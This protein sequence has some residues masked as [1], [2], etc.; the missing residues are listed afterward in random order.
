MAMQSLYEVL[1][2]KEVQLQELQRLLNEA[3]IVLN[4]VLELNAAV[5]GSARAA[6]TNAR[7]AVQTPAFRPD[8]GRAEDAAA[9]R[10]R[11]LKGMPSSGWGA[12][13]ST[14]FP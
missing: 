9:V 8:A 1:R 14:E 3:Q 13:V 5:N 10:E 6:Q 2:E 7:S 11:E 4:R 12:N